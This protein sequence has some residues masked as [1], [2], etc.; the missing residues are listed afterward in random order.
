MLKI[1][2]RTRWIALTSLTLGILLGGAGMQ[3]LHA[4]QAG[5]QRT[6]LFRTD[7]QQPTTPMEV[8]MGTAEIAAGGHAG[9]HSHAGIE[10]GYVLNGAT[11]IEVAGEPSRSLKAGDAYFIPAGKPHDAKAASDGSTKV[12]AFYLVEKGKPLATAVQ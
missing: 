7:V 6:L 10:V 1:T 8:V 12:L 11:V 3:V 2:N 9:Q 4:Q 5:I